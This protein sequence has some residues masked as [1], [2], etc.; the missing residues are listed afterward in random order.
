MATNDKTE[1]TKKTIQ[2]GIILG[3]VGYSSVALLYAI[4]D[5]LA[6]RGFLFTVNLLG[7]VVFR[8]LRDPAVLSLPA[9]QLDMTAIYLFSGLHLI[10]SLLIGFIVSILVKMSE[11]NPGR[12]R[13]ILTV[14]VSGFFVT[15]LGVGIL[16]EGI[17]Q[18]LPWWSIVV[19]NSLAVIVASIYLTKKHPGIW[20]RLGPFAG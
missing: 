3:L 8:G 1:L 19:A 15:I 9:M 13:L 7:M 10:L 14:L 5:F 2:D 16:T 4:T 18:L 17:R 20:D 11:T 6:A 12:A